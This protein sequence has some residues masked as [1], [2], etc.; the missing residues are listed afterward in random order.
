M[1]AVSI[2][3]ALVLLLSSAGMCSWQNFNSN[4]TN[5][6]ITNMV[7]VCNPVSVAFDVQSMGDNFIIGFKVGLV[8]GI[9][10]W[11]AQLV[12]AG[13]RLPFISKED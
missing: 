2:N 7:W 8:L 1:P 9:L 11:I 3:T 13:L 10:V 6:V 4:M 12:K 5:E